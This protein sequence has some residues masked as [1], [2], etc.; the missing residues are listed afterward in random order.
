MNKTHKDIIGILNVCK[1]VVLRF[2]TRKSA[3]DV[4]QSWYSFLWVC[5]YVLNS[6][7]TQN[8]NQTSEGNS[9]SNG[10]YV[11]CFA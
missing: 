2:Y 11:P 6:I 7:H 4:K 1:Y 8:K 10:Q 3:V 9:A 5:F